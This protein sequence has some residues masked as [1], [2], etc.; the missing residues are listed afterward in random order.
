[1]IQPCCLSILNAKILN[2]K[3]KNAVLMYLQILTN[4]SILQE[5][6]KDTGV[7]DRVI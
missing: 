6:E 1:M 5:K 2:A 3:I 4:S 7:T